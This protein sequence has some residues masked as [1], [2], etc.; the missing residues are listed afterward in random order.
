MLDVR[1]MT[2]LFGWHEAWLP[3]VVFFD[4][5]RGAEVLDGGRV[6]FWRDVRADR[7]ADLKDSVIEPVR[8]VV[9]M[10]FDFL[11]RAVPQ[12]IELPFNPENFSLDGL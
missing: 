1:Q 8:L 5:I 11:S 7:I 6:T 12:Q 10:Q 4:P 3:C 9:H 2:G